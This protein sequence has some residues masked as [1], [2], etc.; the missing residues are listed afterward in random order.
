MEEKIKK[1]IERYQCSGCIKGSDISCY[2]KGN[3]ESIECSKHVEGTK[4]YPNIGK[5]FL[6]LPKGFC[7]LGTCGETKITIFKSYEHSLSLW[8]YDMFNIPTWKYLDKHGNTLVRGLCPRI[9][10]PFLH[11]FMENQMAKIT[12]LEI[13]QKDIDEMD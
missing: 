6:G 13:T 7:Q 5:I 8:R 11:I 9:N 3:N 2:K 10:Y 4:I 12:C 1:M